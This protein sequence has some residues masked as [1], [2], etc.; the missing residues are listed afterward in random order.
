MGACIIDS[1]AR[2]SSRGSSTM[3]GRNQSRLCLVP[4]M[5]AG[6]LVASTHPFLGQE[7]RQQ[8]TIVIDF[9]GLDGGTIVDQQYA[10]RGVAFNGP[11]V[12]DY[13]QG[14]PIPGFP[15]SGTNA[16]E[17]C[18]SQEFCYTPFTFRFSQLQTRV[19]LWVGYSGRLAQNRAVLLEVFN[20]PGALI[21]SDRAVLPAS[22]S[23]H[24]I[25]VPLEVSVDQ[26]QISHA[27]VR[28]A[29]EG[30]ISSGLAIDDLEFEVRIS[31]VVPDVT[32]RRFE[33][34]QDIARRAGFIVEAIGEEPSPLTSGT[35]IEQDPRPGVMVGPDQNRIRVVVAVQQSVRVPNLLGLI[36]EEAAD[37]LR[38]RSLTVGGVSQRPS[39]ETWNTVIAQEPSP[40]TPVS[41]GAPVGLVV[42]DPQMVPVPALR[43][44]PIDGVSNSLRHA[45]LTL[46]RIDRRPTENTQGSVIEQNP[47]ANTLVPLGSAV[48]VAVSDPQMVRVPPLRGMLIDRARDAL[49]R[50]R[51]I[52][53]QVD[54]RPTENTQG[55][56]LEQS[57]EANALVPSGSTVSVVIS[58]PQ[59]VRV[60]DLR[61]VTP[62]VA[63]GRLGAI[64]LR[65]GSSQERPSP[66]PPGSIVDHEPSAGQLVERGSTVDVF[67]SIPLPVIVP[68]LRGL[69]LN[70][71]R[72]SLVRL[73]LRVGDVRHDSIV[74]GNMTVVDHEPARDSR[75]RAGTSVN[76]VLSV[77]TKSDTSGVRLLTAPNVVGRKVEGARRNLESL[78]LRLAFAPGSSWD[79]P[80]AQRIAT[81]DPAA[82]VPIAAGQ[83]IYVTP[84]DS[85]LVWPWVLGIVA[86]LSAAVVAVRLRQARRRPRRLKAD[87]RIRARKGPLS[88]A[89]DTPAKVVEI[90]IILRPVEGEPRTRI[91]FG[92]N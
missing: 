89:V 7:Q 70:Q 86:L 17:H 27:Q 28:F 16:I 68:D 30:A 44:M 72:D 10:S 19:K 8:G 24:L 46:G 23:A 63:Q 79:D 78:G 85:V 90:E 47:E 29:A 48:S 67:V 41:V 15:H 14:I 56:V 51:L 80:V 57:P 77:P 74:G 26:P 9:E 11:R 3:I 21:G 60:P 61:G 6:G 84:E 88:T 40:G 82:G 1:W 18:Y 42:S 91:V 53:G 73:G 59:L 52:L 71:A 76:I 92:G 55:S 62:A 33:V 49:G 58:D 39:T 43:G 20:A 5:V 75:V 4:L 50:T 65:L 83:T 34:A 87:V 25:R 64:R 31:R 66:D 13:R 36:A 22:Q 12:L 2:W 32:R 69:G 81:Q 54:R 35:I 37:S 45:R 38:Q